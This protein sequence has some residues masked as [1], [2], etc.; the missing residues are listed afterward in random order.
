MKAII[1]A[2]GHGTRL[3][4]YTKDTPKPMIQV[5][6]KPLL[7]YIIKVLKSH[8]IK[9]ITIKV[10][11]LSNIIKDYFKDGSKFNVNISYFDDLA[12]TANILKKIEN[13]LNETFIV[14]Y[15]DILTNINLTNLINFH[16]AKKGVLTIAI[17]K[18]NLKKTR[19]ISSFVLINKYNK[20]TTF[21]EK[22]TDEEIKLASKNDIWS[23]S[24]IYICE[25]EIIKFIPRD[26]DYDFGKDL[27]PTL[28]KNNKKIY[29]YKI[30]EFFREIGTVEKYKALLKEI[31]NSDKFN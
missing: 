9:D 10:Y 14:I 16:R 12:G 25:P 5:N 2:A 18:R 23:N 20:I 21:V 6:N 15:G 28:L 11:H 26:I 4:P 7:Y 24:G 29:G 8:N 3:Y 31:K 19:K 30:K 13:E 1:L 17:F 22:P 27:F